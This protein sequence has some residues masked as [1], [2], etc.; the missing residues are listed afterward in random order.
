MNEWFEESVRCRYVVQIITRKVKT[1]TKDEPVRE[2]TTLSVKYRSLGEKNM[3]GNGSPPPNVVD[4]ELFV[5]LRIDG[6]CSRG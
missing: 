2:L 3:P 1:T 5:M 4:P 6:G